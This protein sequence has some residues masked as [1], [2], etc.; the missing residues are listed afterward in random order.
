MDTVDTWQ[1]GTTPWA[2]LNNQVMCTHEWVQLQI[3]VFLTS[4]RNGMSSRYH[5]QLAAS[6]VPLQGRL[7]KMHSTSELDDH[8]KMSCFRKVWNP[9]RWTGGAASRMIGSACARI[10]KGTVV[11]YLKLLPCPYRACRW[12]CKHNWLHGQDSNWVPVEHKAQSW[13]L[14]PRGRCQQGD[15]HPMWR[16]TYL[17]KATDSSDLDLFAVISEINV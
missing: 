7:G 12:G 14:R 4:I 10:W 13:T 2:L 1:C 8:Q 15:A 5:S 6:L 3:Q 16:D 11:R 17:A 9:S